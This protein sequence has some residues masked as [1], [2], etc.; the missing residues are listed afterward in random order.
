M[1]VDDENE[2]LDKNFGICSNVLVD[3]SRLD[4]VKKSKNDYT[5]KAHS[6][7]SSESK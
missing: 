1:F 7:Y 4:L 2:V 5:K 3:T 6:I